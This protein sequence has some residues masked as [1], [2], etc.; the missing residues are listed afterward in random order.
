MVKLLKDRELYDFLNNDDPDV[1][2]E[3]FK[4]FHRRIKYSVRVMPENDSEVFYYFCA[5]DN[6]KIVGVLKLRVGNQ[7]SIS[8]PNCKNWMMHLSI[9][10]DYQGKGYSKLLIEE[11]MKFCKE[12]NLDILM[13][14]YS[15]IGWQR[16]RS[17][18]HK[19]AEKYSVKLIDEKEKPE[20]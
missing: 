17:N 6:E 14:G 18:F 15:D 4:D 19:F 20:F 12:N 1:A 11:C 3:M 16:I 7:G 8:Y 13:S 2:T 10:L 5:F 9:D